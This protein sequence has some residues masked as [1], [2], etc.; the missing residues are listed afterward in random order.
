MV[1]RIQ[2][3]GRWLWVK[4][5]SLVTYTDEERDTLNGW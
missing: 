2:G 3:V 4:A 1:A 5:R